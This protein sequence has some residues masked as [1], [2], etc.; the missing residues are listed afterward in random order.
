MVYES[1]MMFGPID[2]RT[3]T[4]DQTLTTGLAR[5][6][7]KYGRPVTEALVNPLVI[8]S[9]TAVPGLAMTANAAVPPSE[10]WLI[11]RTAA[12]IAPVGEPVDL[13]LDPVD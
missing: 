2:R 12:L 8:D 3:D 7:E 9:L 6:A 10:V 5:Y 13:L 1:Y 4:L 11:G